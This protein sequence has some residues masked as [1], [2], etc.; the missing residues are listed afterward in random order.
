MQRMIGNSPQY[1]VKWLNWDRPQDLTWEPLE[2]LTTVKDLVE[3]FES[4]KNRKEVSEQSKLKQDQLK[5]EA[6]RDVMKQKKL[7]KE[8]DKKKRE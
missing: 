1:L 2:N 3:I 7:I 6:K 5:S 4:K 8:S